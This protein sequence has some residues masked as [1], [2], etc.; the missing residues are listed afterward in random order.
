MK[1]IYMLYL[2]HMFLLHLLRFIFTTRYFYEIFSHALE[3]ILYKCAKFSVIRG[4]DAKKHWKHGQDYAILRSTKKIAASLFAIVIF[5][6][7]YFCYKQHEKS[8]DN[9]YFAVAKLS[10]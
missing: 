2:L 8:Y 9:T 3:Y 4:N 5:F 7:K 10:V 1:I 6:R